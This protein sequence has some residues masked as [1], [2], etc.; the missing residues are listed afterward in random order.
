MDLAAMRE[1]YGREGLDI[2][3]VAADP[4]TQFADWF[5]AWASTEPFDAN[6]AV[7]STVDADGGPTAR[8][9]LLKG[10]DDRGFVFYTNRNSDKG[11]HLAATGRA[12][13]TFVW[14]VI[15]RQVRVVGDVEHVP[16]S[17]S[18]AYFASRPR[19]AQIGAWASDQSAVLGSRAELEAA[20]ADVAARYADA[21]PRP[22]HWGGYLIRPSMVEFWQGRPSRLHDR[23]RYRRRVD[24]PTGW[25]IER[26]A[27]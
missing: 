9:V 22:P 23:V 11:R 21:V 18:D 26:L 5:A 3:D 13:L 10:A 8:A 20:A 2:D 12:A 25:V 4:L 15:E 7:L 17:E 19:D 16:D 24:A 6:T 1:Q 27:P 14:R